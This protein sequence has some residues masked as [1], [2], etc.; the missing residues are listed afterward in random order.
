M[1]WAF[2]SNIIHLQDWLNFQIKKKRIIFVVSLGELDKFTVLL[3]MNQGDY[4][5][6]L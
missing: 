3:F 1:E 2:F 4:R 5:T 6:L